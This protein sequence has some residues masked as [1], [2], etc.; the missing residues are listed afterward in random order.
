V[1]RATIL[2]VDDEPGLREIVRVNLEAAGY[3]VLE[4]A[5][6]QEALDLVEREHPDLLILDLMLPGMDGWEVLRRLESRPETA[7]LPVIILTARAGDEDRLR[8]LEE[9][10]VQYITKPFYPEDLV[11]TVKIILQVFNA[12]MRQQYRQQLIAQRRKLLDQWPQ[13]QWPGA[14][15]GP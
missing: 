9:G 5:E 10:A 15:P 3:R 8:G 4:A 2:V 6:G 14:Q 1:E 13:I 7:G 12:G 11:A